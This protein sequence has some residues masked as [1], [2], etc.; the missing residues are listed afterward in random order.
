MSLYDYLGKAAGPVLGKK[1]YAYAKL[2]N[3]K[4][5]TRDIENPVFTGQVFLYEKEFIEEYF[6]VEKLF[7]S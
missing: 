2:R 6:Q 4:K 5:S 3:Q 7:N 1:V